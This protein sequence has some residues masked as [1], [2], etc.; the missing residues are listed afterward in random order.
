MGSAG[1][2][3]GVPSSVGGGPGQGQALGGGDGLPPPNTPMDPALFAMLP[4]NTSTWPI[5][6]VSIICILVATTAVTLRVYTRQFILNRVGPDDFMAVAALAGITALGAITIIH[7]NFGLGTHIYDIAMDPLLIMDFF[8]FFYL[9]VVV[10]NFTLVFVKLSLFLQYYRL[11][12]QVPRYRPL[13]LGAGFVVMGWTI[14]MVFSMTFICVPVYAY[15]DKSVPHVCLSDPMM[16]LTNSIGNIVTDIILLL[17][18]MPVLWRLKLPMRQKWSVIGIF[19]LGFI[20][21]IVSLLRV[22]FVFDH[23]PSSDITFDGTTITGWTIAEVTTGLL[24]SSLITLRPLMSKIAPA[25]WR[26]NPTGKSTGATTTNGNNNNNHHNNANSN[27]KDLEN[28]ITNSEAGASFPADKN[29]LANNEPPIQMHP[30]LSQKQEQPPLES[31]INNNDNRPD[32]APESEDNLSRTSSEIELVVQKPDTPADRRKSRG[33]SRT[34]TLSA[35]PEGWGPPPAAPPFYYSEQ[36]RQQ[37]QG[38]PLTHQGRSQSQR[39]QDY[40]RHRQSRS[41]SHF[42]NNSLDYDSNTIGSDQMGMGMGMAGSKLGRA[43]STS[44][45]AT[46]R[47]PLGSQRSGLQGGPAALRDNQERRPHAAARSVDRVPSLHP[48]HSTSSY[49]TTPPP[50]PPPKSPWALAAAM[51]PQQQAQQAPLPTPTLGAEG[52]GRLAAAALAAG[53]PAPDHPAARD[54][55][56]APPAVQAARAQQLL[57]VDAVRRLVRGQGVGAQGD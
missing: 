22:I 27:N 54:A 1:D 28:N 26:S 40:Q 7:T 50:P 8:K 31:T 6:A 29:G 36:Q 10:Y 56:G 48:S 53:Q 20:T 18:P 51:P 39:Q 34:A 32:S 11:V 9:G 41:A 14:A 15:W 12:D 57:V 3:A 13:F 55:P 19:S 16:Q 49:S 35:A 47:V 5:I 23:G 4:H 44:T 2:S 30:V 52:T 37:Q 42:Q 43:A 46:P 21:C 17:L 24:A 45:A 33:R 38:R 25:A